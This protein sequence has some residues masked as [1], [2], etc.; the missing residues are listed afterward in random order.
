MTAPA[1]EKAAPIPEDVRKLAQALVWAVGAAENSEARH[2]VLEDFILADRASQEE[3]IREDER[4]RLLIA[5]TQWHHQAATFMM[6]EGG[7]IP[8]AR[9]RL[10]GGAS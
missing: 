6:D 9:A 5:A 8:E 10:R 7:M 1:T 4:D 3:R 2:R